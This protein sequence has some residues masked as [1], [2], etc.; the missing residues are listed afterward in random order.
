MHWGYL[1]IIVLVIMYVFDL[2]VMASVVL[3]AALY[4]LDDQLMPKEK[5]T[6]ADASRLGEALAAASLPTAD[7]AGLD[8]FE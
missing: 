4:L 8:G 2:G 3:F 5:T 7:S 6:M 1:L